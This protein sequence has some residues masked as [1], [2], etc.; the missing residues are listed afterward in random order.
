MILV[1]V[2]DKYSVCLEI[3][4]A[5]NARYCDFTGWRFWCFNFP[6]SRS[7]SFFLRFWLR[8]VIGAVRFRDL[9]VLQSELCGEESVALRAL[10]PGLRDDLQVVLVG[11]NVYL[12][13]AGET[14]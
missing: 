4:T 14:L 7:N 10:V 9:M 12:G 6:D 5:E 8:T 11:V 13:R 1:D 2:S 3:L